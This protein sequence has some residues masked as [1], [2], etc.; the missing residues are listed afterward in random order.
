MAAAAGRI[1]LRAGASDTRSATR[2]HWGHRESRHP[3]LEHITTSFHTLKSKMGKRDPLHNI[4]HFYAGHHLHQ[5]L[6]TFVSLHI[7]I[8]VC[9]LLGIQ[10]IAIALWPDCDPGVPCKDRKSQREMFADIIH[11]RVPPLEKYAKKVDFSSLGSEA[12]EP[13]EARDCVKPW[14]DSLRAH[15]G[16]TSN[17][18]LIREIMDYLRLSNVTSARDAISS[19]WS[20]PVDFG[21]TLD[22]VETCTRE[23]APVHA[24]LCLLLDK[25]EYAPQLAMPEQVSPAPPPPSPRPSRL[26]RALRVDC[27]APRLVGQASE[28]L[29]FVVHHGLISEA[30]SSKFMTSREFRQEMASHYARMSDE[31]EA[32]MAV[33]IKALGKSDSYLNFRLE[34]WQSMLTPDLET[35]YMAIG[36]GDVRIATFLQYQLAI[37]IIEASD[38]DRV[39]DVTE[40]TDIGLALASSSTDVMPWVDVNHDLVWPFTKGWYDG[41]IAWNMNFVAGQG[42]LNIFPKLFIP[43]VMCTSQQNVRNL[44][45]HSR[46]M[47]LKS[48]IALGNLMFKKPLGQQRTATFQMTMPKEGRQQAAKASMKRTDVPPPCQGLDDP[49]SNDCYGFGSLYRLWHYLKPYQTDFLGGTS[50]LTDKWFAVY[51]TI[52]SWATVAAFG[53]G[54]EITMGHSLMIWIATHKNGTVLWHLAQLSFSLMLIVAFTASDGYGM[55]FLAVGLWKFG[56]P[57]TGAPFLLFARQTSTPRQTA[58]P[59]SSHALT[60]SRRQCF[61]VPRHSQL[62]HHVQD[63]G[64][65][66]DAARNRLPHRRLW[67]SP[68]S[69]LDVLH[70]GRPH[71]AP[72]PP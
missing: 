72:L 65:Q 52:V 42:S 16:N 71:D 19:Y 33:V 30:L 60:L 8:A 28:A 29:T 70:A 40:N 51:V 2:Q 15:V 66:D 20:Q 31:V 45:L 58:A 22:Q 59:P 9:I 50:T 54:S 57:E 18:A 26:A 24:A 17:P 39:D 56:F 3:E 46:F 61:A 38:T 62:P 4:K 25:P 37:N 21:A 69:P 55:P 5:S 44:W 6:L 13:P 43:S 64:E 41:Y 49:T 14:F 32:A 53:L 12:Y 1:E 35:R 47:S 27:F 7:M 23:N 10:Y 36:G 34:K 11:A 48:T 68:P 63:P 67:H